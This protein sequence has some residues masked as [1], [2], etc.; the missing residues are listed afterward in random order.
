MSG[1]R[2]RVTFIMTHIRGLI[3]PQLE[4]PEPKFNLDRTLRSI[5]PLPEYETLNLK[6]LSNEP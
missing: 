1:V 5:E 3:T 4:T 6:I 2:S